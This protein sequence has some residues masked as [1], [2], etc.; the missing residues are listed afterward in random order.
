MNA[1]GKF[2]SLG[3]VLAVMGSQAVE[4]AIIDINGNLNNAKISQ[5]SY[6]VNGNPVTQSS[7][8]VTNTVV[9]YA[10]FVNTITVAA[11]SSST[12]TLEFYNSVNAVI[13]NN[14]F[15]TATGASPFPGTIADNGGVGV[16]N[17]TAPTRV[18]IQNDGIAAYEQA[19]IKSS[20]DTNLMNYLFYDGSLSGMPAAGVSDFDILYYH[21]WRTSDFIVVAERNGNTFFQL[22]PLGSDGNPIAGAN[23]LRFGQT[24][25]P[26]P[27][28]WNSGFINGFD[29]FDTQPMWFT[30]ASI[31]K[32]FEGTSV[33]LANQLVYG[34]RIDNNGNADVKFF[35][36][37]DSPFTDNPVNPLV[38]IPEPTSALLLLGTSAAWLLLRR[39]R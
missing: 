25:N 18:R 12:K 3:M 22:V 14:N 5:V 27:H 17:T 7:P 38:P 15:T 16:Y 10:V 24:P 30:A 35:G 9:D 33:P 39:R 2:F 36:A 26:Q 13:R 23:T 19:V 34:Y 11:G 28:D 20:T 31:T 37:S 32:F 6:V 8:A 4:A 21:A 1:V 29:E